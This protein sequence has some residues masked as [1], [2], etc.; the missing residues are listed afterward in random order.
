MKRLRFFRKGTRRRIEPE[1]I[2]ANDYFTRLDSTELNALHHHGRNALI[3]IQMEKRNLAI[4]MQRI[5]HA[6]RAAHAAHKQA[7]EALRK[8]YTAQQQMQAHIDRL[9]QA[10]AIREGCR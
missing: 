7:A 10:L 8:A 2:P 9:G 5:V 1:H 6:L 4:E 3:G